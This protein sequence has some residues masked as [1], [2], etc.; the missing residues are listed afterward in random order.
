M[1]AM[2]NAGNTDQ[3]TDEQRRQ[4]EAMMQLL[5]GGGDDVLECDVGGDSEDIPVG[6]PVSGG[7][8]H[9]NREKSEQEKQDEEMFAAMYFF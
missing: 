6:Q 1:R 8:Q 4:A 2:M 9:Q 3:Q 5:M 7:N